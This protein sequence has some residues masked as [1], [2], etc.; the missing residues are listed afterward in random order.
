MWNHQGVGCSGAAPSGAS[1]VASQDLSGEGE[2]QN[3]GLGAEGLTG[4][5]GK[6]CAVS[7]LRVSDGHLS[8]KLHLPS[9]PSCLLALSPGTAQVHRGDVPQ[10]TRELHLGSAQAWQNGG[11]TELI[12]H[13]HLDCCVS[14]NVF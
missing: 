9:C 4:A 14:G 7:L 10:R 5:G 6:S 2:R 11:I 13:F 1:A 3:C 8:W 12:S